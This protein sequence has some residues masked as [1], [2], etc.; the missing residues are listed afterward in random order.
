MTTGR[1]TIVGGL[2]FVGV[3]GLFFWFAQG[4]QGPGATRSEA[5]PPSLERHASHAG[6][7][8]ST[9]S[10]AEPSS[11]R[12]IAPAA[13]A[14]ADHAT[15]QA[16]LRELAGREIEGPARADDEAE[17]AGWRLGRARRRI[18]LLEDRAA[19][20]E[21]I[22]AR[23]ESEGR[24]DVAARQQRVI[25][26]TRARLEETRASLSELETEARREGS[27][28][29]AERGYEEG[30][31]GGSADSPARGAPGEQAARVVGRESSR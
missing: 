15:E 29:D 8:G 2:A 7:L 22:R 5:P 20:T 10:E 26:R 19:R 24:T 4:E 12:A 23:L 6:G 14:P 30:E 21:A 3:A 1:W 28:A 17:S 9:T 27:L 13:R 16:R 31:G 18:E 11:E 25:D